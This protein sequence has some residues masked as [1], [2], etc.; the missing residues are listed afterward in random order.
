MAFFM[1][2][3]PGPIEYPPERAERKPGWLL[4]IKLWSLLILL[5][6]LA[7]SAK[8]QTGI[9]IDL[10]AVLEGAAADPG[11]GPDYKL[12]MR[13]DLNDL[14]MLPGQTALDPFLGLVYT[15]PGQPYSGPPWYYPGREGD[16]YDSQG[17]P[18]KGDAGYPPTVVDWVL[19]SLR[20]AP[21]GPPVWQAA[22][23]LHKDG[24]VQFL[25][26]FDPGEPALAARYW[27]VLE[28][29]NHLSVMS[30]NA[31]P[32]DMKS[33][34]IFCDFRSDPGY[35]QDPY[36]FSAASCQKFIDTEPPVYA[37]FAGNGDQV[38]ALLARCDIHLGDRF[39]WEAG[40]GLMY[41][42]AGDY[43][44][45]GDT[46]QNDRLLWARNNGTFTTVPY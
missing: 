15:P 31:L 5:A 39:A 26:T 29:R 35:M 27:V 41:Y 17:D 16:M 7:F 18:A 4:R 20:L 42:R 36:G 12:P 23:F 6:L 46:N 43:N 37:L 34:T 44:L 3:Q 8:A 13:A 19:V 40:N 11:G 2:I 33:R 45:N 25:D 1:P 28:H 38:S 10:W 14:Q 9:R 30:T 21:D 24:H 22:G 32:V